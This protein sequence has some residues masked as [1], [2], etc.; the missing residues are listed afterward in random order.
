MNDKQNDT[1]LEQV[2]LDFIKIKLT[3]FSQP[4]P[5]G[6]QSDKSLNKNAKL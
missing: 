5:A 2:K 6:I 4:K 1:L 3:K